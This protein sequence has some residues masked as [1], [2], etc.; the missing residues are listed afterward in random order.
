MRPYTIA[1]LFLFP[2]AIALTTPQALSQ[3]GYFEP[4]RLMTQDTPS[5]SPL[6]PPMYSFQEVLSDESRL[7]GVLRMMGDD[8]AEDL[9]LRELIGEVRAGGGQT[10][11][12]VSPGLSGLGGIFGHALLKAA[13]AKSPAGIFDSASVVTIEAR[14]H[15]DGYFFDHQLNGGY[16][17]V[18]T[19]IIVGSNGNID[20]DRYRY[21]VEI[22][23][24]TFKVIP[25][26][27]TASTDVFPGT[28]LQ[29]NA[30]MAAGFNYKLWAKGSQIRIVRLWIDNN[31]N[32]YFE[33]NERVTTDVHGDW[34]DGYRQ[35]LQ[36]DPNACIDMMFA[37]Y[38]PETLPPGAGPPFYCLGR[39]A[40]PPLIN[41]K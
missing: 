7:N 26:D 22:G 21:E 25:K 19:E 16:I 12:T 36:V 28:D 38:P 2:G 14:G 9:S 6:T 29:I 17:N 20:V 1:V 37:H 8:L 35:L 31:S 5:T 24:D 11:G 10:E 4:T 18:T 41:T 40:N 30:V 15:V 27:L 34:R 33:P 3:V 32:G 13:E 39:C 23:N